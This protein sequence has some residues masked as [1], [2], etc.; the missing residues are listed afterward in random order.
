[1]LFEVP[2]R[3]L[4]ARAQM[5]ALQQQQAHLARQQQMLARAAGVPGAP[6]GAAP[7]MLPGAQIPPAPAAAPGASGF[8]FMA[9]PDPK[10]ADSFGFVSDMIGAKR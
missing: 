2:C 10:D 7:P 9:A 3:S 6:P 4:A 8:S 5:L 1:M